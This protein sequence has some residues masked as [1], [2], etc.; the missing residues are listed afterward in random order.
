MVIIKT[1]TEVMITAIIFTAVLTIL[2]QTDRK[3]RAQ[4]KHKF[5]EFS[6]FNA[7]NIDIYAMH[8]SMIVD[9]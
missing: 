4:A 3:L 2:V 9:F 6:S 8:F 7:H 5:N 1:I